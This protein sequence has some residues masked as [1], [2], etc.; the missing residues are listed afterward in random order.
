MNQ[1]NDNTSEVLRTNHTI[2]CKGKLMDFSSPRI[3]GIL[4]LTPDSFYDGGR[5]LSD[6]PVIRRVKNMISE[7]MD[8]LDIGAYSSRPGATDI[9][10]QEELDRL[11]PR[12]EIIRA[13]FPDL[14]VSVDTFR[15]RIAKIV[16]NEY[17]VDMINDISGGNL[18]PEMITAIS[19]LKIPY[20]IMH[21]KGTPQDMIKKSYYE[22]LRRELFMFF[23]KKIAELNNHGV[24]DIIIDPGFGFGK[25][26]SHNFQ[27]LNF[28]NDFKIFE[29]PLLV[30]I[31]RKSMIY[32]TLKKTP[33]EAL[34]GTTALH[35][36]ALQKGAK[37]LR[38]HDVQAAKEVITLFEKLQLNQ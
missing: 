11:A 27:L 20:I 9:S 26:I 31:S 35:M 3:M 13:E 25:N 36:V 8:I 24:H 4:N 22:D 29:Q 16:C 21:M 1:N 14:P 17:E 37:I 28:L 5:D 7:G 34:N 38:V 30:G 12:L 2:L 6:K 15:S 32:K 33:A 19:E 23:A 18:D 10:E